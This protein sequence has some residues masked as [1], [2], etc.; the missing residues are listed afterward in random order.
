MPS[1]PQRKDSVCQRSSAVA[2]NKLLADV[3]LVDFDVAELATELR[4]LSCSG[5]V[6]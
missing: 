1:G 4:Q 5:Q 6:P 3:E 2:N